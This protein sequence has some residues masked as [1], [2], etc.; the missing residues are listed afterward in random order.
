MYKK[1]VVVFL[2]G[3]CFGICSCRSFK[4]TPYY[5]YQ[6]QIKYLDSPPYIRVLLGKFQ[7]IDEIKIQIR[8]KYRVYSYIADRSR[9]FRSRKT[10]LE[11]KNLNAY[12]RPLDRKIK[13][14]IYKLE[15]DIVVRP[16]SIMET[17]K[18]STPSFTNSYRG[19]IRLKVLESGK[20]AVLNILDLESYVCGVIGNEMNLGYPKY[21]LAAQAVASRTFALFRMKL[22]YK[23]QLKKDLEVDYDVTDDIYT[24]VY[25]GQKRVNEKAKEAVDKT[26][27]VL[28]TYD[29]RIVYSIF[30]DTCAGRTEPGDQVF[31]LTLI[32]PLAGTECGYCGSSKYSSWKAEYKETEIIEKLGLPGT[33]INKI[34]ALKTAPGGH[35]TSIA[36]EM[37]SGSERIK[38]DAQKFRIALNP[39]RLRSTFFAVIKSGDTFKFEGGG[40]GH[41]VGMCQEGAHGMSRKKFNALSILEYFY[42]ESKIVKIY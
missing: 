41:A 31:N 1:I 10:L 8:G 40:W 21:A 6:T 33:K 24:Q 25:G 9:Y 36:I 22:A 5:R 12:A 17:I 42:P 7:D 27:G 14:G 34:T 16:V 39:N 11:G 18:L 15:E 2:I 35:I 32:P 4:P 26:C 37:A 30:H 3:V 29:G 13:L 38:M 19:A 20:L 28:L 23:R